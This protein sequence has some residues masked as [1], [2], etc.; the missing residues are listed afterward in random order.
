MEWKWYLSNY[1]RRKCEK[2]TNQPPGTQYITLFWHLVLYNYS[3]YTISLQ[4]ERIFK[5]DDVWEFPNQ[6][7]SNRCNFNASVTFP[8]SHLAV[9]SD[10]IGYLYIVDT[11]DRT[12]P[13]QWK[14]LTMILILSINFFF[15]IVYWS[16]IHFFY[17]TY[18]LL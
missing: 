6:Y 14:V 12:N 18:T 4:T 8:T 10:G 13:T 2:S 16:Y 5:L 7:N 9:V 17:I 3:I 15:F 1:L 11:S